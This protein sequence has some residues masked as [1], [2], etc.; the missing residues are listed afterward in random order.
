MLLIERS[1]GGVE[2]KPIKTAYSAAAGTAYVTFEN[3]KVP[4]GNLLGKVNDGLK[5]V[6]SNFNHERWGMIVATNRSSRY[7]LEECL[8]WAVQ[9]KVFGKPLIEQPVI[10]QK[11]GSMIAKIESDHAML[12]KITDQMNKMT[13]AEMSEHLAGPIALLKY[14]VTRTATVV[15]DE[16][17]QIFGG[18]ALTKTGMGRTIEMFMRTW[19]ERDWSGDFD[20]SLTR[21]IDTGT[22]S[23]RF[24]AEVKRFSVIWGSGRR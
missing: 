2:T 6:L 7:V 5:V 20:E 18:R 15:A 14:Q 13:Y 10:R 22:N 3:V 23:M 19:V 21:L 17:C 24:W 8:K 4:V 11:I 1:F 9:R 16:A 12:E